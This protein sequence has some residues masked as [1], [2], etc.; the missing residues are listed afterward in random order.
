MPNSAKAIR[1]DSSQSLRTPVIEPG[2]RA[3]TSEYKRDSGT[4]SFRRGSERAVIREDQDHSL[5]VLPLEVPPE[6]P[7]RSEVQSLTTDQVEELL[8]KVLNSR[9]FA[10]SP[11]IRRLLEYIVRGSLAGNVAVLKE[12]TLGLEVFDRDSSFDPGSDPIVRVEASRLR[13]RLTTYYAAEGIADELRIELPKGRYVPTI[14]I[15]EKRSLPSTMKVDT[16]QITILV[17]PLT[18]NVRSALDQVE[19]AA[20]VDKL[21]HLLTTSTVIRVV[22]RVSSTHLDPAMDAS[23]LGAHYG[24][25]LIVE[26]SLLTAGNLREVIFYLVDTGSGYNLW[27]ARYELNSLDLAVASEQI[28]S[29]LISMTKHRRALKAGVVRGAR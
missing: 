1:P 18:H 20:I 8:Q 2:K 27:S 19:A 10:R 26:G 15:P 12:Y 17:L 25:D 3:A 11:R 29:D 16:D 22:A 24:A 21:T 23:Q 7:L 28:A 13:N 9:I 5:V 14:T 4:P 6:T